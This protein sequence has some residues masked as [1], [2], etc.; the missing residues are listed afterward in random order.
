VVAHPTTAPGLP[1]VRRLI[2]HEHPPVVRITHAAL[3]TIAYEALRSRDGLETGGIL[4]GSD[5]AS[6]ILIS[7]A[8][9]PGPRAH[10]T[11][12]SFLR[13]LAHA[14]EIAN[15]A[16]NEDGHQ[17]IGEWHTH[18]TGDLKPSA[19]DLHS[20]LQH[21]HDPELHLDRFVAIIVGLTPDTSINTAVWIIERRSVR[22]L[23]LEATDNAAIGPRLTPS[24][25]QHP[26]PHGHTAPG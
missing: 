20:Y 10:R 17:W 1:D 18:P 4:L 16:W 11:E 9:D 7:R 26:R 5:T 22:A 6:H 14:Q 23:S 2:D 15:E 19:L 25:P 24:Q 21:L 12:D 13:D 3:H 8:G